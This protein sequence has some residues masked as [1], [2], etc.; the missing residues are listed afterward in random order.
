MSEAA[1]MRSL[2]PV[3]PAQPLVCRL[4]RKQVIHRGKPVA[5]MGEVE[6]ENLSPTAVEITYWMTT[7]QYLNLVVTSADGR[8]VS[9]GHFGDRFAPTLEPQVLRL[10]PGD[11]FT[12]NVHLLA[13][14]PDRPIPP[15][16]YE[17]RA[18]YE[19]DVFRATSDPVSVSVQEAPEL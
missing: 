13:T 4:R 3:A 2:Q 12:A 7:L 6:L 1:T 14:M 17:V 15:G 10:E 11:K 9:E 19:Y 8:T 18:V 16:A 5:N